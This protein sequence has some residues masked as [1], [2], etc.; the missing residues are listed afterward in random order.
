MSD[1][2]PPSELPN[3]CSPNEA[4]TRIQRCYRSHLSRQKIQKQHKAALTIQRH[5]RGFFARQHLKDR[6]PHLVALH[7]TSKRLRATRERITAWE[8]EMK[9]IRNVRAQKVNE[10]EHQRIHNSSVTLQRWWRRQLREKREVEERFRREQE[11]L[12]KPAKFP[13]PETTTTSYTPSAA[14]LEVLYTSILDRL[15]VSSKEKRRVDTHTLIQRLNHAQQLLV[16]LYD[17][18]KE[19]DAAVDC[20]S[21]RHECGA[22]IVYLRGKST[23]FK[24]I[25]RSAPDI[26]DQWRTQRS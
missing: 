2:L 24:T 11:D 9:N 5:L 6:K 1:N 25:L 16:T 8:K 18:Q 12:E 22:Y 14:E 23:P 13:K 26:A 17:H 4:A 19:N 15:P 20:G 21:L 3:L 10:W 7:Y